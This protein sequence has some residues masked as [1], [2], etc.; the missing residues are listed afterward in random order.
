MKFGL[1]QLA[2]GGFGRSASTEYER[3]LELVRLAEE[4]GFDSI[5]VGEHHFSDYGMLPNSLQFLA[6]AA[7]VTERIRLGTSVVVTPLHHPVR[8]AEEAAFVDCLSKGRLDLGVGRGYQPLELEAFGFDPES[9]T[10]RFDEAMAFLEKAWSTEDSFDWDGRFV[11][12]R[13]INI[14]PR[15][16][17]QPHPPLWLACVSP[18]TFAKAGQNGYRI[19]TSPNFTPIEMVKKN[20]DRYR[21]ALLDTG[22]NP[23]D[24]EWPMVQ[25]IYVGADDQQAY[26]EPQQA[27]MNYFERLGSLLPK[28]LTARN[29]SENGHADTYEQFRRTQAKLTSGDLRYDYLYENSVTYGSPGRVIDR[30]R[31]LRDECDV[32]YLVGWFNFGNLD[33]ELVRASL[34]RFADEV[35]PEFS[36]ATEPA[37]VAV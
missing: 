21:T 20:F 7:A 6:A 36:D 31:F 5:W 26:E 25:Q 1:V 35:M 28:D 30:I 19:M 13:N 15:P 29:D 34:R 18:A 37:G 32:N 8:I 9:S 23:S 4:L 10:D 3:S 16:V 24:F 2:A 22:R 12:G 14:V 17:Q 33:H 27:C 11:Q